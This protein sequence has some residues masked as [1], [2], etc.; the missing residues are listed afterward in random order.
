VECSRKR[1]CDSKGAAISIGIFNMDFIPAK[2]VACEARPNYVLWVQFQD[3]IEGE[4]NLSNLVG[5][6]VFKAW[7][8]LPFWESVKIDPES[9][10]V[11][12]GDEIDLDPYVIKQEIIDSQ[13]RPL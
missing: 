5:K 10:T 4:I 8:S 12:W 9:E 13:K 7:E 2:I 1:R 11:A 3:G 6:G